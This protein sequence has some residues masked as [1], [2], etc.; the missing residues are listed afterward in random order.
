MVDL[1][2]ITP[3]I[4]MNV[5]VISGIVPKAPLQTIYKGIFPLLVADVLHITLLLLVTSVVLF[6]PELMVY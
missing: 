3:P 6:L 1:G 2:T 5:F 4:G